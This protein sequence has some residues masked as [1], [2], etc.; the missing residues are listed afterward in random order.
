[1]TIRKPL[2]AASAIAIAFALPAATTA[3]ADQ[4]QRQQAPQQGQQQQQNFSDQDLQAYASA[5]IEISELQQEFQGQMQNAESAEDQQAVQEEANEAMIQAIRDAG[6]S[7]E[8]YNQI[9]TAAQNDQELAQKIR[10]H[11]EGEMEQ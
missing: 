6:L 3:S 1:M 10:S 4:Q 7:L 2:L 11:M 5:A 9:A 8:K